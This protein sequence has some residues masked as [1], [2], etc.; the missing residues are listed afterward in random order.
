MRRCWLRTDGEQNVRTEDESRSQRIRN[1]KSEAVC[2]CVYEIEHLSQ[3]LIYQLP[4]SPGPVPGNRFSV[5]S[6]SPHSSFL[7]TSPSQWRIQDFKGGPQPESGVGGTTT[8]Y[9]TQNLKK[10]ALKWRILGRVKLHISDSWGKHL[11]TMTYLH[12]QKVPRKIC[13]NR[14]THVYM[15]S[16]GEPLE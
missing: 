9:L 14:L 7:P 6:E 3:I 11:C 8:Y 10:T 16:R 4:S 2:T 5:I 15:C 13:Q 1:V 12:S